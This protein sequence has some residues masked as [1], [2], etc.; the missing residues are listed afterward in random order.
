MVFIGRDHDLILVLRKSLLYFY[1]IISSHT[2][3]LSVRHSLNELNL[4][5][6]VSATMESYTACPLRFVLH[7]SRKMELTNITH[8]VLGTCVYRGLNGPL[9][10]RPATPSLTGLSAPLWGLVSN[11]Y[12]RFSD[13]LQAHGLQGRLFQAETKPFVKTQSHRINCSL[14]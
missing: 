12:G 6:Q 13:L 5:E 7:V 11:L 4:Q 1:P 10:I 8:G 9:L 3:L 14:K 2:A